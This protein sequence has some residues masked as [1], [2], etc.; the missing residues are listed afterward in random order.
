RKNVA[1]SRTHVARRTVISRSGAREC[2]RVRPI[3]CR[4]RFASMCKSRR[5]EG[6]TLVEL[7]VVIGIIAI[8][9]GVLLPTLATARRQAATVKC[10]AELRDIGNYFKMYELEYKGFWPPAR[11]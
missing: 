11:L 1:C 6:F 2:M 10:A 8:L 5:L 3:A 4:E 9:I 7:L